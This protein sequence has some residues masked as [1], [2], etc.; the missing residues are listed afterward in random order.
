MKFVSEYNN[1]FELRPV[2]WIANE[3]II[4]DKDR[5][6]L[7]LSAGERNVEREKKTSAF[8]IN[9]SMFI[10]LVRT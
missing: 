7:A 4:I 2:D 10:S 9:H 8:H 6:Y 5:S 1:Y 3:A